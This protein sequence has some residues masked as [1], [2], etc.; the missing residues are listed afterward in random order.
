MPAILRLHLHILAL[1]AC[2]V[3]L[4]VL[5]H[6]HVRLAENLQGNGAQLRGVAPDG[7][8]FEDTVAGVAKDGLDFEFRA[9]CHNP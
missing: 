8:V 4:L 3:I 7:G 6:G 1:L 2:G 5:T 9:L